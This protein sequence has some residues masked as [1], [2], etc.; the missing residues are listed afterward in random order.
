MIA[1]IKPIGISGPAGSGKDTVAD[2]L[3]D[4][5]G[6]VKLSFATAMKEAT[7]VLFGWNYS[8]PDFKKEE[9]DPR[10][11]FSPREFWQKFGTDFMRNNFGE[12]I[13]I[14]ITKERLNSAIN[15]FAE[16]HGM[17]RIVF[18]DVRFD[19]EAEFVLSQG[20]EMITMSR[21]DL[22]GVL[23]HESENGLRGDLKGF[24]MSNS[25][26]KEELYRSVDMVLESMGI[27][28]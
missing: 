4:N 15:K 19:N 2:Y 3:C 14:T 26:T 16:K 24:V 20:G 27:K 8:H 1:N 7:L 17:P 5:Y 23:A 12:D 21:S 22:L 11:G 13:W 25:G 9:K 10:Y 28:K 18:S 6:F